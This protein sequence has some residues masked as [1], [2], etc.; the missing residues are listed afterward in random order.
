MKLKFLLAL[1]A[2]SI[3]ICS[4]ENTSSDNGAHS[5]TGSSDKML[6]MEDSMNYIL[7]ISMTQQFSYFNEDDY[8]PDMMDLAMNDFFNG[9]EFR[10]GEEAKKEILTEYFRWARAF[11]D[12]SLLSQTNRF[13]KKNAKLDNV[14]VSKRGLQY[15]YLNKGSEVGVSPDGNDIVYV[16]YVQGSEQ[17]GKMWDQ[18]MATNTRDT[19][20]M[21]LNR[22]LS[23]F[24][25]MCQ[26]MKVGDKVKAWLPPVIGSTEGRDPAGLAVKNECMW[27]E[28]E[29]LKITKRS[30]IQIPEGELSSYPGYFINE[31]DRKK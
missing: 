17:Q 30:I 3:F 9:K 26:L 8:R 13:L 4:C 1:I 23:G 7:G 12:D 25:Q 2:A 15:T 27:M 20:S 16:R 31:E 18:A 24:S 11:K 5:R 22:E 21:A 29:L 28:I 14:I 19:I 10:I 6:S